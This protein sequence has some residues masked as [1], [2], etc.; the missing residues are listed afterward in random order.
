MMARTPTIGPT[1]AAILT[2]WLSPSLLSE[3]DGELV[4]KD[5]WPCPVAVGIA[6]VGEGLASEEGA[7]ESDA[8]PL[9]ATGE[10]NTPNKVEEDPHAKD[11]IDGGEDLRYV[12]HA[13]AA[14]PLDM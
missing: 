14:S 4:E 12:M 2:P 5:G 13:G 8:A 11:V 10:A 9:F 7:V 3:G 6:V 1:I